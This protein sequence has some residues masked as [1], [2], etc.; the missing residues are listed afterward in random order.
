[1]LFDGRLTQA[2]LSIGAVVGSGAA[3]GLL[4]GAAGELV[5][6]RIRGTSSLERYATAAS[7]GAIISGAFVLGLAIL[8]E[9]AVT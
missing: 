8:E 7:I 2:L 5:A 9:L 1:M 4:F 6:A 3:I